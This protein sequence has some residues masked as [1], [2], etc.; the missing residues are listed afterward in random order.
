[1]LLI[2][3]INKKMTKQSRQ[4]RQKSI[5]QMEIDNFQ[6]FFTAEDLYD[7]PAVK[8]DKIGIAT[9]YRFLKEL[10]K[11]NSIHSYL[12]NRKTVYSIS[13]KNHCHFS[14]QHCGNI[15]HISINSI[16]FLK[17]NLKGDICHFQINIEGICN[18][19]K[20]AG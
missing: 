17:K 2:S 6:S 5:L 18:A 4:T 9:V 13:E 20:K 19:C 10:K 11:N 7:K 8:D 15:T 1:M 14:C 12:C 3:I 16:D